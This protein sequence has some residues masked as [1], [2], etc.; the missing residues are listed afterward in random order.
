MTRKTGNFADDECQ[1]C[2]AR[3]IY[4]HVDG[5]RGCGNLCCKQFLKPVA[6]SASRP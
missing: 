4:R 6:V 1:K 3:L 5:G 2:G